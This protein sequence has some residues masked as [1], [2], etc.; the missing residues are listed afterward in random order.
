[1]LYLVD[2]NILEIFHFSPGLHFSF[3][4]LL[5]YLFWP[6]KKVT[7]KS[8]IAEKYGESITHQN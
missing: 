7:S 4:H 2:E 3:I 6:K 8:Y 5:I 1:M